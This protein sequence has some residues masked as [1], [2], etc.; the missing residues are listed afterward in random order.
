MESKEEDADTKKVKCFGCGNVLSEKEQEIGICES[1]AET[2]VAEGFELVE[3]EG[4]DRLRADGM[5]YQ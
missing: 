5:M 1:C 2:S 4:R 3:V